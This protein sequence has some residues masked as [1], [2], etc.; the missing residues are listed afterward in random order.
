MNHTITIGD[1]LSAIAVVGG[2][3]GIV[4]VCIVVLSL[5]NPFRS[6]H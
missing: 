4:A 5:L 2:I 3:I 1:L 6:G